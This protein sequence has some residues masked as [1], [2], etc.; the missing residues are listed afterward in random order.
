MTIAYH[1]QNRKE[2]VKALRRIG[3]YGSYP[4]QRDNIG[5]AVPVSQAHHD[6]RQGI[7]HISR[8]PKLFSHFRKTSFPLLSYQFQHS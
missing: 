8:L 6:H 4:G 2:L 7:Q 1:S 3:T 5:A